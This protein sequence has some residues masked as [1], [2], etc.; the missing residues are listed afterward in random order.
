[1]LTLT[2]LTLQHLSSECSTARLNKAW[3][4]NCSWILNDQVSVAGFLSPDFNCIQRIQIFGISGSCT[5][6]CPDVNKY[7][8]V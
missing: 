6:R 5:I 2:K 4:Q 1:M 3:L 7:K 8:Q